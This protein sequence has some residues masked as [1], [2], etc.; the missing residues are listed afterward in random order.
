[1]SVSLSF[2]CLSALANAIIAQLLPKNAS[3][4]EPELLAP[5]TLQNTN[6]QTNPNIIILTQLISLDCVLDMVMESCFQSN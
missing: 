4:P 3:K 6:E 2:L 5:L 1:M